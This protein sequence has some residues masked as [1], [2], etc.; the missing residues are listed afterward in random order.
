MLLDSNN[1]MTDALTERLVNQY[2]L[3]LGDAENQMF[4]VSCYT[5]DSTIQIGAICE[6]S[7]DNS[8]CDESTVSTSTLSV[9][10][11]PPSSV[12][13]GSSYEFEPT[14]SYLGD[15]LFINFIYTNLPSW[16]I[17][18]PITGNING[19]P[20]E[21]DIGVYENITLTVSNET[22]SVSLPA[23]SITVR[24]VVPPSIVINTDFPTS[25]NLT[26]APFSVT[27]DEGADIEVIN[28]DTL[29]T[30]YS[31]TSTGQQQDL[32]LTMAL[33]EGTYSNIYLVATDD[34][35]NESEVQM[36][37]IEIDLTVEGTLTVDASGYLND[38]NN[39]YSTVQITAL[40]GS[41]NNSS[42]SIIDSENGD[43][44]L[45]SLN[46]TVVDGVFNGQL[47]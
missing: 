34:A 38:D 27:V 35:G 37:T 7:D 45:S 25:T 47:T 31:G 46:R 19:S 21:A 18:D 26:N 9:S 39:P 10:G 16:L 43:V 23:F 28:R 30:L 1:E 36:G 12:S 6:I 3:L 13:V 42:I 5:P 14:V 8:T 44:I 33:S 17:A 20:E 40:E 11:T 41:I 2:G 29:E 15:V 24:A 22:E 4:I 32:T